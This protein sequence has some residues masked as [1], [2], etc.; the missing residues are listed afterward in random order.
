[1]AN[2]PFKKAALVSAVAMAGVLSAQQ[3]LSQSSASDLVMEE[4][5]VTAQKREE[6]MQDVPIAITALSE[7]D[8]ERRGVQNVGDL[9]NAVPNMGG[10]E[11]PGGKGNVSFSL[12]GI[13]SGNPSNL[14]IDPANAMYVDGVYVGK[15]IGSAL[16]VAEIQ[17]DLIAEGIVP[18]AF[19]P[20]WAGSLGLGVMGVS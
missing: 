10:Y 2:L 16:D 9:I 14:S 19:D 20:G 15:L 4:V 12:R 11:A 7:T 8:L 3:A 18:Y 13:S 17:P 6:G 1:M 5:V